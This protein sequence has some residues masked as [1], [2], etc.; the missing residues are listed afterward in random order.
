MLEEVSLGPPGVP[1]GQLQ[2]GMGRQCA[3]DRREAARPQQLHLR[4]EEGVQP[5]L[6]LQPQAH[7]AAPLQPLQLLQALR[8]RVRPGHLMY[9]IG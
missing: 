9:L 6:E 5:A 8:M 3:G 4:G 7:L 2:H 1:L